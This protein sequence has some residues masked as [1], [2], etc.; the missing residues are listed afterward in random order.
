MSTTDTPPASEPTAPATQPSR[1]RA[2]I[3]SLL[4]GLVV[5]AIA[6]IVLAIATGSSTPAVPASFSPSL[7]RTLPARIGDLPLLNEHGQRT[8]LASFHGR[9]VVLADFLTSCQDECPIS[10]GAFLA[11]ERDLRADGLSSK[12]AVVEV[13]V[14]PGRDSVARLAAYERYTGVDWTLLTGTPSQL[15][16]FWKYFGASY[17]TVPDLP[18]DTDAIDWETGKRYT[19][20]VDHSNNVYLFDAT[21]NERLITEGLP[22]IGKTLPPRLRSLLSPLGVDHLDH[23]GFGAWTEADLRD[24]VGS[25]LGRSVPAS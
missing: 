12:V 15:A 22:S 24:A 1:R 6:G 4:I 7:A 17:Q 9:I 2:R 25:L 23:P 5:A 13:T 10:T 18:S 14:D 16:T 8:T 19:Y 11:F 20:D 21:G 3:V